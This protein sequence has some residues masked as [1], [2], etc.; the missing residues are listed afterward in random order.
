MLDI[1]FIRENADLVQRKTEEKG[2]KNVDV[3]KVL[4][5]DEAR[6]QVLSQVEELRAQRNVLTNEMKGAKPSAEQL[7]QG[8]KLK[9]QLVSLESQLN[10]V[11]SAFTDAMWTIP[12]VTLDDVPLGGVEDSVEL[13]TWVDRKEC[14]KDHLDFA[15]ARDW[16][17]FER[18]A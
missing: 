10:E 9:E 4:E 7:E 3:R 6:R 2:Y 14:A 1:Q 12:N 13:K 8:K 5:A 16:V 11:E 15:H 17:D 18:G